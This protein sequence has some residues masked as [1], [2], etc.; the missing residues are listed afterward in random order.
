MLA[1]SIFVSALVGLAACGGKVTS[2]NEDDGVMAPVGAAPDGGVASPAPPALVGQVVVFSIDDEQS[3]QSAASPLFPSAP[4]TAPTPPMLGCREIPSG[5]ET[6]FPSR[7]AG[8]IV[9]TA[10]PSS[11]DSGFLT[12][13]RSNPTKTRAC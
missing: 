12:T 2:V 10:A 4:V 3:P 5:F 1:R 6:G 11:L 13:R 8:T 9:V 7:D